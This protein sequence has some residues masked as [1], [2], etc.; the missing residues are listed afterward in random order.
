MTNEEAIRIIETVFEDEYVYRFN[1]SITH[2]ALQMAIEALTILGDSGIVNCCGCIHWKSDGG[3]MMV[4][5]LWD[6]PMG[7]FDYCSYGNR[8]E[9]NDE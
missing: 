2:K 6:A 5:D 4:C 3:A 8:G 7:D 9:Q 1:D